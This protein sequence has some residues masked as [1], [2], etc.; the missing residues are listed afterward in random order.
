MRNCFQRVLQ[1]YVVRNAREMHGAA[2]NEKERASRFKSIWWVEGQFP[3]DR[4][5]VMRHRTP[6]RLD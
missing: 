5:D 4:Y 2:R 1:A 3:Q 6:G